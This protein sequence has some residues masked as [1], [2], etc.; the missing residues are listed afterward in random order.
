MT[1]VMK[2][3]YNGSV[4]VPMTPVDIPVGKVL[5]FSVLQEE[6][7]VSNTTKQ[8]M[9][10]KH[11]SNNLRKINYAEPLPAEFDEILSQRI[12]FKEIN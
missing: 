7:P 6:S 12:H 4:F 9:A 11:I 2:T 1:T 3:Y 8:I 5:V 10:F